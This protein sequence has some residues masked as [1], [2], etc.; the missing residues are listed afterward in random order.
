[1]S[2]IALRDSPRVHVLLSKM[3]ALGC[4]AA[5]APVECEDV[6][7]GAPVL[8][9]YDSARGRVVMNPRAPASALVQGEVTRAI[10][11]E[12]V[13]AYDFCRAEVEPSNCAHIACTEVR[14]ANLSGDCDFTV[15]ARRMPVRLASGGVAGRQQACVRRRAELS[16]AMHAACGAGADG[17]AD[18][19]ARAVAAV[20]APCYADTAPFSSN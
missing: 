18:A 11:H 13:H 14:A 16:V 6:F 8:G 17:A 15:E 10:A 4:S 3:R 9:G 19:A 7:D 2:A 1:M 5:S 20:W 12:F